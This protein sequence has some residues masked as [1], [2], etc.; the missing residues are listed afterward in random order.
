MFH[1]LSSFADDGA[2]R[3]R[4]PVNRFIHAMP[5][6]ARHKVASSDRCY[7]SAR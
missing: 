7:R 5:A 4:A 3:C 6:G 1:R 2:R